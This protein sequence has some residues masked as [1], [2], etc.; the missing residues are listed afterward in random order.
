MKNTTDTTVHPSVHADDNRIRKL[1]RA[2][3]V[4]ARKSLGQH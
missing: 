4:I 1:D 3:P 2:T